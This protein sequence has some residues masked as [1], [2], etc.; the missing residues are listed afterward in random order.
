MKDGCT[1][2]ED[3][4]GTI[5][6]LDEGLGEDDEGHGGESV[7]DGDEEEG[8]AEHRDAH[9]DD[10]DDLRELGRGAAE[11]ILPHDVQRQFSSPPF[12]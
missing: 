7:D 11:E 4:V 1:G 9:A 5:K 10:G 3:H 12:Q 2:Q 6:Y 8:V